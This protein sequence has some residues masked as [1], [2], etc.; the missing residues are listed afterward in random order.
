MPRKIAIALMAIATL[1]FAETPDPKAV[2]AP[3]DV[4]AAPAEAEKTASGLASKV[5]APGKGTTHPA[6][7]DLVTVRYSGW[8]IEGKK[9]DNSSVTGT[10]VTFQLDQVIPGL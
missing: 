9:V 4:A 5:L 1:T 6:K 2:P 7:I 8:T 10:P 3:D